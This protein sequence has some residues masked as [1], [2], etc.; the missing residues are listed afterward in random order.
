MG[1]LFDMGDFDVSLVV[2]EILS[3]FQKVVRSSYFLCVWK[4]VRSYNFVH[5]GILA[6]INSFSGCS[7]IRG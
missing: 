3:F 4:I 7:C 5:L 2:V 1:M 6:W